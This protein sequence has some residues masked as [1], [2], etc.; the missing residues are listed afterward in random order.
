MY[1][2]VSV[3]CHEGELNDGTCYTIG[4]TGHSEWRVFNEE[5]VKRIEVH[6]K[7]RLL[8]TGHTVPPAEIS[9]KDAYILI[10]ELHK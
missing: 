4:K 2:L 10:Y 6:E 7:P 1:D 8:K 3:V 9:D 5:E